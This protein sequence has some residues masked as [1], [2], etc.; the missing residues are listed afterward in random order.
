MYVEK[1]RCLLLECVW[2][3]DLIPGSVGNFYIEFLRKIWPRTCSEQILETGH[4]THPPIFYPS[5][6]TS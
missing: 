1:Q 3:V 2:Y 6:Q 4:V 5:Y